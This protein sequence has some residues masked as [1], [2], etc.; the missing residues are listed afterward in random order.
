MERGGGRVDL[1]SSGFVRVEELLAFF[2]Q[3]LVQPD[4]A[5][6]VEDIPLLPVPAAVPVD[7]DQPGFGFS[8]FLLRV[9]FQLIEFGDVRTV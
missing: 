4:L 5:G 2:G 9:F 6:G 7:V 1:P 8:R 3:A